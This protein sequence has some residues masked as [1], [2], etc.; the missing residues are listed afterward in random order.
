M[1]INVVYRMMMK[2]NKLKLT[3]NDKVPCQSFNCY[4]CC[5]FGDEVCGE[6]P[7]LVSR[8]S[9]VKNENER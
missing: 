7:C 1:D 9:E 8:L 4:M 3:N 6:K 5:P 2:D